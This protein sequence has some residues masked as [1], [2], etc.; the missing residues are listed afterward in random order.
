MSERCHSNGWAVRGR[1]SNLSLNLLS[2][3]S[4]SSPFRKK[5]GKYSGALWA[6]RRVT[7]RKMILTSMITVLIKLYI[8]WCESTE[9]NIKWNK[10]FGRINT[11]WFHISRFPVCWGFKRTGPLTRK[12]P[13]SLFFIFIFSSKSGRKMPHI[14]Q[15]PMSR[16]IREP[17]KRCH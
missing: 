9:F 1:A 6:K 11:L 5:D 15:I 17:C 3:P 14:A 2:L 16:G 12:L 7:A 4:I 13:F 8:L 10:M